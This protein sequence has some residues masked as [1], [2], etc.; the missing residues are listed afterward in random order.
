MHFLAASTSTDA[1]LPNLPI[2]DEDEVRPPILPKR[3]QLILPNEDNFRYR[4]RRTVA[5]R[6]VCPLRNFELEGRMQEERLNAAVMGDYISLDASAEMDP[7][8]FVASDS[9]KPKPNVLGFAN[10]TREFVQSKVVASTQPSSKSSVPSRLSEL[11]RPPVDITFCGSFQAARDYAK[12]QNKWLIVNV[13]DMSNFNCQ[14]LNRDIWSS[15]K[16][17][18]VIKKYFIFWQVAIDN[19]DGH[20][21]QVFY[22]IQVFP[23]VG[24][25]DPRTGEE[26]LSYKTGF[27]LTLNEFMITLKDYLLENTPHPNAVSAIPSRL[28]FIR[29]KHLPDDNQRTS[30]V[31]LF[32]FLY[33]IQ[34][35]V[36]SL[37][38]MRNTLNQSRLQTPQIITMSRHHHALNGSE[39]SH[40]H[41]PN[42]NRLR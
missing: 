37:C 36:K 18:G 7:V 25:I 40:H 26:K 22:G 34:T 15:E 5:A 17:R 4:K 38:W 32:S 13:Q 30:S 6:T 2:D 33:R 42:K 23:Y 41:C 16:L 10:S 21:F 31:F 19:T 14:V 11:F 24:I 9:L 35:M 28:L 39:L 27:Q 29:I 3:E 12:E 20:R 8:S 1:N